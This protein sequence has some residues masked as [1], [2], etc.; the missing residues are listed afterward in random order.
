MRLPRSAELVLYRASAK[1]RGP[2]N[3]RLHVIGALQL[4]VT[5][6]KLYFED[7]DQQMTH[8]FDSCSIDYMNYRYKPE[9]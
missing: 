8:Y 1:P 6:I 4:Q 3:L 7:S 2:G 9:S 5:A